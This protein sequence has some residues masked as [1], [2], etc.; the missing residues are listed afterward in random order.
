MTQPGERIHSLLRSVKLEDVP[1]PKAE[2]ALG[3]VLPGILDDDF[4]AKAVLVAAG[5]AKYAAR[6]TDAK[7]RWE[8]TA[9]TRAPWTPE[10]REKARLK[11]EAKRK[12]TACD[13]PHQGVA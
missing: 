13:I 2:R 7:G 3:V 11:K 1:A 10:R 12:E 5:V 6:H 8:K 9:H 4:E